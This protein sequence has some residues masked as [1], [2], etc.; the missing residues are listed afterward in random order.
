[1][2]KRIFPLIV[3]LTLCFSSSYAVDAYISDLYRQIDIAFADKSENSLNNILSKNTEDSNYYLLENYAMKKIRHL[4]IKEDYEFAQKASIIV[5][6]NN[7][8]NTDAIEMYTV[9]SSSLEIQEQHKREIEQKKQEELAK[10]QIEKE[11]KRVSV[12]KKYV[13]KKDASG[14]TVFTKEKHE[15]YSNNYW[16]FKFGLFNGDFI[17]ES[18]SSYDSFRYG[19]SGDFIYEY[20][21]DKITVGL[22][23]EAEA[24]IFPFTN[25]DKTML[26]KLA[27]VPKIGFGDFGRNF[28]LRAGF[29]SILKGGDSKESVLSDTLYTPVLGISWDKVSVGSMI[30]SGN[31]DYYIG[32]LATDNIKAAAGGYLNF[33]FPIADMEKIRLAFN[34]G[35]KDL[36]Y[37]K[38][39][40]IENRAGIVL[41]IGAENV[42][43]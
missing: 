23:I 19:I 22:D 31:L 10:F 13:S 28:F 14:E 24:T 32:H 21:F 11:K 25:D 30:F 2:K 8:D 27:F 40:G 38:D 7:L 15:S 18:D 4:L 37:V 12:E 3:V 20:S 16:A 6:D 1:M 43:K 36:I 34:I 42:G 5:I 39:N 41:A 35:I 29:A 17:T 9:I 26:G 33:G